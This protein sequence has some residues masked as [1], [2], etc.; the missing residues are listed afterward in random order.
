MQIKPGTPGA[1]PGVGLLEPVSVVLI[2]RQPF[3][4]SLRERLRQL[5]A[6]KGS[7]VRPRAVG[8][9]LCMCSLGLWWYSSTRP[10]Q[11]ADYASEGALKALAEHFPP[12][13]EKPQ[14]RG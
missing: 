1:E 8:S 12:H 11:A 3:Y 5:V 14:V 4:V 13:V 7:E 10:S 9:Q 6:E 2:T